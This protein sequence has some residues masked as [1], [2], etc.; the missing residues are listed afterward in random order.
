MQIF[1]AINSRRVDNTFNVFEG[2]YKNYFFIGILLIMIG[3]QVL[4]IFVSGE[5]FVVT[6]L[7]GIPMGHLFS[8]WT[9]V[10]AYRRA[11]PLR[12]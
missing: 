10:V 7:N 12:S 3:G 2:L 4:I 1:N 11:H 9:F 8:C 6:K 5:A